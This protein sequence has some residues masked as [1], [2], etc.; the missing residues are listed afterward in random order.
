MTLTETI[1]KVRSGVIHLNFMVGQERVASGSGFILNGHLVTNNHVFAGPSNSVVVLRY[2]PNAAGAAEDLAQLPYPVFAGS[3]VSGSDP[4]NLDF[5]ILKIPGVDVS[6][7]H[8]FKLGDAGAL[9]IGQS[10]AFLGFPLEHANLV[11]HAGIVS[12]FYQSGPASVIQLD[13]SVNQSNSGGPLIHPESGEVLGIITRKGTGLSRLFEQLLAVFDQN[14]K[15]LESAKSVMKIAGVDPVEVAI[16]AQNQMKALAA[17]I[18]RSSNVG[19][20]YAFSSE[21]L[22]ADKTFEGKA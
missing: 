3:L 12:S 5:A 10:V 14:V 19:I 2:H 7:L 21:H 17:E 1:A 11:C 13:A 15:A 20:G 9:S 18:L 22:K 4:G 8:S 6:G 16:V